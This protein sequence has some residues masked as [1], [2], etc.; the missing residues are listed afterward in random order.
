V[1]GA[2]GAGDYFSGCGECLMEILVCLTN[3]EQKFSIAGLW[4]IFDV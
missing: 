2:F 1:G 4:I 3:S